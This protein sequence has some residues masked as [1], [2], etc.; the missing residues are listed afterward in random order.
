MKWFDEFASEKCWD[1]DTVK[2]FLRTIFLYYNQNMD[3][4]L[5]KIAEEEDKINL[6]AML[7]MCYSL[8]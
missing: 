6:W 7:C 8:M 3:I 2:T 4:Y 5:T 1:E